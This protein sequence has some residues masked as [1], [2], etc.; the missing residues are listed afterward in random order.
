MTV[1]PPSETLAAELQEIGATMTE[2]WLADAGERGQ[3][4]VDSF[5]SMQ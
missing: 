4:I 5:R 3:S 1:E 2:E